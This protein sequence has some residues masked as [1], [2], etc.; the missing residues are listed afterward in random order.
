MATLTS[1]FTDIANAIRTKGGT[2]AS[3]VPT[4][5]A[6]SISALKTTADITAFYHDAYTKF[7][8]HG[9]TLTDQSGTGKS[10]TNSGSSVSTATSKF[11]GK[12]I[13]IPTWS[14]LYAPN[15][16]SGSGAFTVEMWVYLN[17]RDGNAN[18]LH[19]LW[20]HGG[21]N[22]AARTGGIIVWGGNGFGWYNSGWIFTTSAS[23]PL[24]TWHHVA[25]VGDGSSIKLYVNGVL[26]CTSNGAYNLSTAGERFGMNDSDMSGNGSSDMYIQ[27]VRI[28]NCARYTGNFTPP[29]QSHAIV[30]K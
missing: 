17:P 5:M 6:S 3:I 20:S 27:G 4:N 8:L 19:C 30:Y 2:S 23:F 29:Q 28:S 14:Y 7:Y 11:G 25:F 12:S 18:N 21:S 1:V 10:V 15:C 13:R 9:N 24:Y 26:Q 22:A 16:I